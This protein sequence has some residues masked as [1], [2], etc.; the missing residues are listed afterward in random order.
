MFRENHH[1]CVFSHDLDFIQRIGS[2]G[3]NVGQFSHPRAVAISPEGNIAVADSGTPPP[4]FWS[5]TL[6]CPLGNSRIQI[7]SPSGDFIQEISRVGMIPWGLTS[8]KDGQFL[9][10]DSQGH[11]LIFSKEG[12]YLAKSTDLCYSKGNPIMDQGNIIIIEGDYLR[13]YR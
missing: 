4:D 12:T 7:F 5:V 1:I 3:S 10:A 8:D 6:I 9:V 2:H 13:I 11:L